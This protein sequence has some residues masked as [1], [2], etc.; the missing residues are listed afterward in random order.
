MRLS[1]AS[2]QLGA[3]SDR[4]LPQSARLA[5]D[6]AAGGRIPSAVHCVSLACVL[7]EQE[8]AE[9]MSMPPFPLTRTSGNST[10]Y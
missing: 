6:L 1:V 7:R 9:E 8:A 2:S 5:A 3:R 4:S 10:V